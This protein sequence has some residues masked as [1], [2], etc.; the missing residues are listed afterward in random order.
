M[1][2]VSARDMMRIALPKP[3]TFSVRTLYVLGSGGYKG[4]IHPITGRHEGPEGEQMYSSTLT[5]TSAL[6]VDGWSTPHP[7]RFTPWKDPVPVVQEAGWAPGP[8]WTGAENFAPI[9][10]RSPDRPARS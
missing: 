7:G 1:E 10:I 6:D 9:R 8:V 3:T 4:K 5:S 2:V